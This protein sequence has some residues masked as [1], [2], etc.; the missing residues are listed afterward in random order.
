[1]S[2]S[3]DKKYKTRDKGHEVEIYRTDGGG[4][5]PVHA[6]YKNDLGWWSIDCANDGVFN[7]AVHG[8]SSLDLIE[9]PE[10]IKTEGW[11]NVYSGGN[12]FFHR[13]KL[14][15]DHSNVNRLACIPINIECKEGDGL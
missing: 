5:F 8:K 1:M 3:M 13:S 7:L 14:L 11:L 9:V 12:G 10:T 4:C 2:I 15:A 6:G